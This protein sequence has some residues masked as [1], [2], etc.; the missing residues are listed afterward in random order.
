MAN[1]SGLIFVALRNLQHLVI[2][3]ARDTWGKNCDSQS[4]I[5]EI[6]ITTAVHSKLLLNKQNDRVVHSAYS[7]VNKGNNQL[8]KYFTKFKLLLLK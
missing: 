3:L 7:L 8:L 1:N 5:S 2:D 6:E 4:V